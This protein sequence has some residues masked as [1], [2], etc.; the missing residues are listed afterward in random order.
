MNLNLLYVVLTTIVEAIGPW[1]A[2]RF[3]P[4]LPSPTPRL[5]HTFVACDSPRGPQTKFWEGQI[6][7]QYS[8]YILHII[9]AGQPKKRIDMNDL[10]PLFTMDNGA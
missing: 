2:R 5:T 6:Y 7:V 9:W 8:S 3:P 4:L 10:H 1:S